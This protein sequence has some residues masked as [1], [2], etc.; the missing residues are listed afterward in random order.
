MSIEL[1]EPDLIKR[2]KALASE[3]TWACNA[4]KKEIFAHYYIFG[5]TLGMGM[6]CR[7]CLNK[8]FQLVLQPD[9]MNIC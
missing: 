2:V 1:K 6:M 8:L 3:S 7:V 4:F 9:F 5:R